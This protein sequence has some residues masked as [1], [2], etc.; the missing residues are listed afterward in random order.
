MIN[1][2]I[3]IYINDSS[4]SENQISDLVEIWSFF[5]TPPF[6]VMHINKIDAGFGTKEWCLRAPLPNGISEKNRTYWQNVGEEIFE[7][8]K[9]PLKVNLILDREPVFSKESSD[10]DTFYGIHLQAT[11]VRATSPFDFSGDDL[12]N[13]PMFW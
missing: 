6:T 5:N 3:Y 12:S 9:M 8:F 2:R 10:Y 1:L 7:S 13:D 4:I 11:K